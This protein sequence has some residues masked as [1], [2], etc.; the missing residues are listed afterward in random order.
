MVGRVVCGRCRFTSVKLWSAPLRTGNAIAR[1]SLADLE[2]MHRAL[3]S[4]LAEISLLT[5]QKLRA[6]EIG[7]ANNSKKKRKP[8]FDK[9]N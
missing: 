7:S 1:Q 4:A 2:P 9:V 8:K 5:L 3:S 6:N